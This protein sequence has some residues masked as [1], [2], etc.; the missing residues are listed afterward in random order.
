MFNIMS[1]RELI[2]QTCQ[3]Y[4]FAVET[5]YNGQIA[6]NLIKKMIE[7]REPPFDIIFMDIDMP[8][9]GGIEATKQIKDIIMADEYY[10]NLKIQIIMCSAYE[11][12]EQR[13]QCQKAGADDYIT[14]P[15]LRQKIKYIISNYF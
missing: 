1:L 10:T 14:K 11:S 5:A 7:K 3:Q 13:L 9:L 6:V 8:V 4:Q 15:I 12:Q 2:V